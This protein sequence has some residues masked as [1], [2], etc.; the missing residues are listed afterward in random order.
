MQYP[1]EETEQ[2]REGTAAHWVGEQVLRSYQTEFVDWCANYIGQAAPN[3]VII[4]EEMAEGADLYVKDVL[5]VCQEGGYL[6]A[7]RIEQRV[8]IPRVHEELN[9]GTPDCV[10]FAVD[11]GKLIIWDFKYG[12][13]AVENRKNW[14]LI[15]YAIG[16]LDEITGGNGLDDQHLQVEMRIVQPRAF[17]VDGSCRG[18]TVTGSDLRS[19]ANRLKA[20]ADLSMDLNPPT[21]AGAGGRRDL[22][23]HSTPRPPPRGRKR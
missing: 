5:K 7:M 15:E 3:G 21:K 19:Y 9:W 22:L 6:Q 10:I 4:N 2:S 17:H 8:V 12:R 11:K 23:R 20:S 18:W 13:V 14:Q 1:D 16:A